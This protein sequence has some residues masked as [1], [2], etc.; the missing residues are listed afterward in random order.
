MDV[1]WEAFWTGPF[2]AV[3]AALAA[4]PLFGVVWLVTW[5]GRPWLAPR[6]RY[7]LWSLVLVR[8]VMPFGLPGPVGLN[9]TLFAAIDSL[10][11]FEFDPPVARDAD[12]TVA[13]WIPATGVALP[14]PDVSCQSDVPTLPQGAGVPVTTW[15]V[16]AGYWCGAALCALG[17]VVATLRLRRQV[18]EGTEF[19]EAAV[20][21]MLE[22]G[23]RLFGVKTGVRLWTVPGLSGPAAYGVWRPLIL[24]PEEAGQWSATELRHVVWHELAHIARR[25]VAA[26]LLVSLVRVVQWWNPLFWWAQKNWLAEREGTCD[27]LVV[28]RLNGESPGA[29]GH[30]ILAFVERMRGS[31]VAAPGFVG[32]LGTLRRLGRDRSLRR[33]LEQLSRATSPESRR[34][35]LLTGALVAGLAV[36]GLTDASAEP[37]AEKPPVVF[38]LPEGAEWVV[39]A[40]TRED[41]I[42]LTVV[43]YD[44]AGPLTRLRQ[45]EPGVEESLL[46]ECLLQDARG[47]LGLSRD[48]QS[49]TGKSGE[50]SHCNLQGT[51]LIVRGCRTRHERIG[52]FLG[53]VATC[54][55]RQVVFEMRV[56]TTRQSLA[57]LPGS[58]QIVVSAEDWSGA[59]RGGV[60]GAERHDGRTPVYMH[61]LDPASTDAFLKTLLAD[62]ESNTLSAPK[63]TL[64]EGTAAT[65]QVGVQR[66]YVTGLKSA[67][68]KP[69]P[70]VSV[71]QTGLEIVLDSHPGSADGEIRLGVAYQRSDVVDVD[72]LTARVGG[73]DASIQMPRV[74]RSMVRGDAELKEGHTLLFAPLRRDAEG[75][76]ELCLVTAR[77]L[78]VAGTK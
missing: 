51:K 75:R 11:G 76:M 12:E 45:D 22:A 58:G 14:A 53:S 62:R 44:L 70:V 48:G 64:I 68:E 27:A 34:S 63:V 74:V 23:Q 42:D 10:G 72:V 9:Q 66:P 49:G 67:G 40:G 43:V 69:E 1:V 60:T 4:L 52:A 13:E 20:Q 55:L 39:Q 54:G 73:R 7:L 57:K 3:R 35:R 5:L 26:N 16:H 18:A 56:V 30:T 47:L 78:G 46:A 65:I 21:E 59:K 31:P 2:L 61:R 71:I 77:R 50:G 41:D 17:M 28:S 29:Y 8:L 37:V 36:I 38:E 33:R 15:V 6:V 32:F 24:L 19:S 25:D